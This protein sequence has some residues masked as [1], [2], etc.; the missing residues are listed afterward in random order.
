MAIRFS[1][2]SSPIPSLSRSW[3]KRPK[4]G[5]L[6]MCSS[7]N[8]VSVNLQIRSFDHKNKVFEDRSAGIVCYKDENG[9]I[10]CEGYDEGPRFHHQISRF[11][12]NSRDVE[13]VE[14]LQRCWV[15]VGADENEIKIAAAAEKDLNPSCN[16]NGYN[17]LC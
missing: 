16:N 15:N 6:L 9:E 4:N 2:Y 12:C 7:N 13:I 14:L 1:V 3:D 5:G 17:K 10:V 11:T 8:H